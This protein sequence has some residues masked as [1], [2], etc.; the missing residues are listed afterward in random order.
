MKRILYLDCSSGVSGDMLIGSLLSA[1]ASFSGLKRELKKIPLK[2]YEVRKREVLR[3][4]VRAAKFDVS[5]PTPAPS[6][7]GQG[8]RKPL[9]F[10]E[11]RKLVTSSPLK[12]E[13]R[14]DGLSIVRSLFE[15]E[16][17]VHKTPIE[18]IHLHELGSP[19]TVIDV[20]G[21][22]ICMDLLKVDEV[23]SSPLNIGGGFIQTEHGRLPVPAP[24]TAELLKGLPVYS[25]G[26][27]F[28]LVTPTG[29]ALIRYLAKSF[30][31]MPQIEL[32]STGVGAGG[33]D[34]EAPNVLLAFIGMAPSAREEILV[35][36]T[37]I[38]DMDPR[39]Y[40]YLMDR[41]FENG[42]LDVFLTPII[43][44]KSRPAALLSVLCDKKDSGALKEIIFEETS[45]LGIREYAAQRTVLSRKIV[46]RKTPFGPIRFKIFSLNGKEFESPEYDDCVKAARKSGIPLKE[47]LKRLSIK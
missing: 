36:E 24:A 8:K 27:P 13:I 47:I 16:A 45:T 28:E 18:K 22:L 26:A 1:G 5:E 11:M 9:G 39:I 34:I 20:L 30:G 38:D 6:G 14:E 19:D 12:E 41:L 15:A 35:L 29:A 32:L 44:K 2:G 46:T 21:T 23:H 40:S 31:H 43:M 42:V 33:R 3:A 4:G 37:N 17:K 10:N 7:E 25:S